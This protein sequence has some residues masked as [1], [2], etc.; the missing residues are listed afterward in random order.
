MTMREPMSYLE[1]VMTVERNGGPECCMVDVGGGTWM[2]IIHLNISGTPAQQLECAARDGMVFEVRRCSRLE[3][4]QKCQC[5]GCDFIRQ[6]AK[7]VARIIDQKVLDHL[8][9]EYKK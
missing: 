6:S 5:T 4:H 9:S 2:W 1:A 8:I 3:G 7:N